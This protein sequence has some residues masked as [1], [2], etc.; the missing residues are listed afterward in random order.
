[1]KIHILLSGFLTV[2]LAVLSAS[3]SLGS[4]FSRF[5]FSTQG[6]SVGK[7]SIIAGAT[8]GWE[9]QESDSTGEDSGKKQV[10]LPNGTFDLILSTSLHN[11]LE[12]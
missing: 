7:V 6:Q 5:P 3:Q 1:M 9:T 2:H 11:I 12:I 8:S 4:F 10:V